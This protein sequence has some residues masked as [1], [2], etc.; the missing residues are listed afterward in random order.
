MAVPRADYFELNVI[1]PR[2]PEF[3]AYMQNMHV[4]SVTRDG[5]ASLPH[6]V[7]AT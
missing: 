4:D 6:R 2:I 5:Y 1:I 3:R 7:R